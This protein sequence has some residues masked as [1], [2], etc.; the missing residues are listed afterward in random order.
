MARLVETLCYKPESRGF[1]F[2][3]C[4]TACRRCGSARTANGVDFALVGEIV[5]EV[6]MKV[7]VFWNAVP[8]QLADGDVSTGQCLYVQ[9]V[10]CLTAK[11]LFRN[12]ANSIPCD[13]A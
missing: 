12:A 6:L 8:C 2:T 11:T 3:S 7:Q 1:D 13:R 10:N 5:L 9:C 4:A